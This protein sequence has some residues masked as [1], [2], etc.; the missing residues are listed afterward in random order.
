MPGAKAWCAEELEALAD[1]MDEL[2]PREGHQEDWKQ[3]AARL[4]RI[5]KYPVRSGRAA[6]TA[7][8][9]EELREVLKRR[10]RSSSDF[11][12]GRQPEYRGTAR[13]PERAAAATKR[14][15]QSPPP[16]PP[17]SPQLKKARAAAASANAALEAAAAEEEEERLAQQ[18]DFQPTGLLSEAAQRNAWA[19]YFVKTL[20]APSEEEWDEKATGTIS[21]IMKAFTV[22]KG[23][24]ASVR[25]VLEDVTDCAGCGVEYTSRRTQVARARAKIST[26]D[27]EAQLI[28][29]YMEDDYSFEQT[30]VEINHW[31]EFHDA[32]GNEL[33]TSTPRPV[34][35]TSIRSCYKAMQP[36]ES[37]VMDATQGNDDITSAWAKGRFRWLTFVLVS[38]G[39]LTLKE[40]T[41][42][43][44]PR[45]PWENYCDEYKRQL[46]ARKALLNT[47]SWRKGLTPPP[48]PLWADPAVVTRVPRNQL[49]WADG[50]HKKPV[51]AGQGHDSYG[52]RKEV[53]FHRDNDGMVVDPSH[54]EAKLRDRKAQCKH[55]YTKESRFLCIGMIREDM[56]SGIEE[57]RRLLTFVYSCCWLHS[58]A[59]FMGEIGG[60][61]GKRGAKIQYIKEKGAATDWVTNQRPKGVIYSAEP[62]TAIPHVTDAM[63]DE[64]AAYDVHTVGDW[65]ELDEFIMTTD[66]FQE[67]ADG[68]RGLGRAS[69]V[70]H[71]ATARAAL[72]GLPPVPKDHRKEDNPYLSRYGTDWE[73]E[74]DADL[75]KNGD[76]CIT[77]MVLHLNEVCTE[78]FR[79][80]PYGEG[81]ADNWMFY[82]DA[83]SIMACQQ[84]RDWMASIGVLKRWFLPQHG[85]NAGT[86]W[87]HMPTG[88]TSVIMPWDCHGNK[89]VDDSMARHVAV[90]AHLPHNGYDEEGQPDEWGRFPH[91]LKFSRATPKQQDHAY[92]R[93]LH[94]ETG[95]SPTP[96]ELRTDRDKCWG[97][98]IMAIWKAWGAIVRDNGNRPNGHRGDQWSDGQDRR[99]GESLPVKDSSRRPL[100]A[101]ALEAQTARLE[102]SMEKFKKWKAK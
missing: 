42:P 96:E 61:G 21:K 66:N 64:L 98:N 29:D 9:R 7:S 57:A 26:K 4:P 28:A 1:L 63:V 10:R 8:G 46:Q 52:S 72:P 76:M 88:N 60:T 102:A 47:S 81:A 19:H 62:V 83:L 22:P 58:I 31:R 23:S 70:K 48:L 100:H 54:P 49:A 12:A 94:P 82:H 85:C 75:K 45:I 74:I 18:L 25:A 91:P 93:L 24:R 84:C 3:L 71:Q 33:S 65:A 95:V 2:Q 38:F 16:P 15:Q 67:I 89:Y 32:D 30:R 86:R 36:V 78:A 27:F 43:T 37:A 44:K 13:D 35:L 39:D 34:G 41:D 101:D 40:L 55:K 69:V 5:D 99:G 53:R 20:E 50:V 17:Q 90:T 11:A 14:K 87:A 59:D 97:P 92:L 6:Q 56:M 80:T 79:G 68:V 51:T 77:H 73:A